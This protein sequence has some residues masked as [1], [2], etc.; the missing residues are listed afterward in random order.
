M[1]GKLTEAQRNRLADIPIQVDIEP[2]EM[3]T[4]TSSVRKIQP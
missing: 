2:S 1:L 4:V 3:P